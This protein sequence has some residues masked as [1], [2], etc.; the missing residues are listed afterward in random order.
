M[1]WN[2]RLGWGLAV[3]GFVWAAWLDPWSLSEHDPATLVGSARMAAR[4]AQ[5]V[6][7]GMAFVQL[8][9]AEVLTHPAWPP[10]ARRLAAW[11]TGAGAVVYASGYTLGIVW[12]H[13]AWLIP[14]GALLNALGLLGLFALP[15][16]DAG[17]RPPA[18]WRFLL[19]TITFGMLLDA[20]MGLFAAS[21]EWFLPPS[22]GP[23]D[24]VRLRLLRLARAAAVALPVLALLSGGVGGTTIERAPQGRA[25]WGFVALTAGAAGMP[26]ILTAAA[27]L[28]LEIKYLLPLPALAVFGGTLLATVLARRQAR[29]LELWGWLLISTSLGAGLLMG[30]YAFDGPAP[31]PAFLGPYNDFPRRLSRLAHAYG[32]ILGVISIFLARA[33][34]AYAPG[35]PRDRLGV[36][37]LLAGSVVTLLALGLVA[38]SVLSTAWLAPGPVLVA[39]GLV[40]CLGRIAGR[41]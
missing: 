33:Q 30:L 40:L 20:L 13:S 3:A 14:V 11:L 29:P 18:T 21:P 35:G 23:E 22:L 12:P 28:L 39:A 41:A 24:G 31:T 6:I 17:S 26:L 25:R 2:R 1:S 38:A 15:G 8:L 34:E 9:V 10:R 7:L 16:S 36:P 32:I 37:V 19:A 5:A 4:Q 27:M